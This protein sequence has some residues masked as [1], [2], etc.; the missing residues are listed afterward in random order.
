MP[1]KRRTKQLHH[2]PSEEQA[3][4]VEL[5]DA[6]IDREI[7][8]APKTDAAEKVK[9]KNK[10]KNAVAQAVK[11]IPEIFQP[12]QVAWVL[13][14]YVVI[15]CFIFSILLKCDFNVLHE[16]LKIDEDV[17]M[18]WAK[19]LAK[20]ASK[21]APAQWAGMT[22]EIELVGCLALWT[23]TAFGRARIIVAHEKEK[24]EK[25]QREKSNVVTAIPQRQA[26]P[27]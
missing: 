22:A 20:V 5:T 26:V 9:A 4:A 23:A 24:Q 11:E 10:E 14:V 3:S 12:E 15:V 16:E 6:E 27:V 7:S 25:Q 13:D 17:K 1:R 19:P 18:M 2:F 21:Y 8:D